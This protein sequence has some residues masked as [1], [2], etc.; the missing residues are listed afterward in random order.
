MAPADS[1]VEDA[2]VAGD[3]L[4]LQYGSGWNVY[5]VSMVGDNDDRSLQISY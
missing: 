4:V 5:P 1:M 2:E 3:Y